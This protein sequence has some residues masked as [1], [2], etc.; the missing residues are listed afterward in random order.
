[1]VRDAQQ[2]QWEYDAEYVYVDFE[3]WS[4]EGVLCENCR[5]TAAKFYC[6]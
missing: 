4:A 1:L 3:E 6:P 5:L 2:Y